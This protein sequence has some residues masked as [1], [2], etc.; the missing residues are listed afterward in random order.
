MN[1]SAFGHAAPAL[2]IQRRSRTFAATTAR[3]CEREATSTRSFSIR[4]VAGAAVIVIF[5]FEDVE[6]TKA[7]QTWS[8]SLPTMIRGQLVA[9]VEDWM[10]MDLEEPLRREEVPDTQDVELPPEPEALDT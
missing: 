6:K 3:Y 9:S 8:F 7:T 10:L 2:G 4:F 1:D 5:E